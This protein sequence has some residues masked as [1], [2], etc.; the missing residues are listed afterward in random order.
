MGPVPILI[1]REKCVVVMSIET[2]YGNII[3]MNPSSNA[4][5]SPMQRSS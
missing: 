5:I 4:A 2:G 3:A 1:F